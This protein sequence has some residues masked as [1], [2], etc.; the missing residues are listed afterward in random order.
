MARIQ[1]H[2]DIAAVFA[3]PHERQAENHLAFAIGCHAAPS[4]HVANGHFG[5]VLDADRHAVSG[6]DDDLAYFVQRAGPADALD[7]AR[8]VGPDDIAAADVLVIFLQC[9]DHLVE[10]EFVFRELGRFGPHF[11]LLGQPA[12]GVDFGHA[13]HV[14]ESRPDHPILERPQFGKVIDI[15]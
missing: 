11:K 7:Q 13:R 1:G 14:A 8:F 6:R 2:R 10:R 5:D 9:P 15:A 4:D 3:H 12:P